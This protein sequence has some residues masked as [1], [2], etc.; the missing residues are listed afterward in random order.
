VEKLEVSYSTGATAKLLGISKQTIYKF[1]SLEAPED[2]VIP[3]DAW[4]RLPSGHIR[5]KTWI[6]LD[7]QD[8]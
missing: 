1:L 4:F 2:A 5:I 6:I 7:L 3:K 8:N